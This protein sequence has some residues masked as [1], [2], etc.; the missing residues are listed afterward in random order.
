MVTLS[1]PEGV[2]GSLPRASH[3][4]GGSQHDCEWDPSFIGPHGGR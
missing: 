3:V 4:V 1:P 2:A